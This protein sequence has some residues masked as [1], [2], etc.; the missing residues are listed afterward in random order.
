MATKITVESNTD[1]LYH[2][3]YDRDSILAKFKPRD[4]W[5]VQHTKSIK[6]LRS[7]FQ[8]NNNRIHSKLIV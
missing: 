6:L 1:D 8:F 5:E 2:P 7:P 3:Q 4:Q